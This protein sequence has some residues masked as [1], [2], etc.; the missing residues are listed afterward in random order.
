MLSIYKWKYTPM[1]TLLHKATFISI[2]T[3]DLGNG[4]FDS[5]NIGI[6]LDKRHGLAIG[7]TG[8]RNRALII[9]QLRK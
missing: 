1:Q 5:E 3:N 4:D 7:Q 9:K 8:K 2:Y 6:A